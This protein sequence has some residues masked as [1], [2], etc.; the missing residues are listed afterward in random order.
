MIISQG[1]TEVH[2]QQVN[3]VGPA[4]AAA[5]PPAALVTALSSGCGSQRKTCSR[6]TTPCEVALG[7]QL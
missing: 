3:P 5:T 6:G 1:H 7:G 2:M 4:W